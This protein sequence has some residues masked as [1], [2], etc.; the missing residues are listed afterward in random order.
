[1]RSGGGLFYEDFAE[2]SAALRL[3][4]KDAELRGRLGA[5]GRAY[6]EREYA[7]PRVAER[8]ESLLERLLSER[9]EPGSR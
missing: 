5:G 8:T 1:L 2:F 4:L 7:W 3:L 9:R 6:V